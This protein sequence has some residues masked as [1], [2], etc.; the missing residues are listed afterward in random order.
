MC[1]KEKG[2][3][4]S[5]PLAQ[6]IPQILLGPASESCCPL[7]SLSLKESIRELLETLHDILQWSLS[8][9][10]GKYREMSERINSLDGQLARLEN[11]TEV[12]ERGALSQRKQP[13]TLHRW[14]AWKN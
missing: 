5:M 8:T 1:L 6:R 12:I 10:K 4:S 11:H 9:L 2:F 3:S 13:L 14:W 7:T